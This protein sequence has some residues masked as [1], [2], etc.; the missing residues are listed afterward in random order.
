MPG[1]IIEFKGICKRFPGVTAL[2]DVSFSI[3]RG[4]IHALIGENGAGKSTLLRIL[5]G[6]YRQDSGE[7]LINGQPVSLNSPHDSLKYGIALIHQEL[8]L[9]LPLCVAENIFLGQLPK[10]R[11]L[12][13]IDW[14]RMYA[15]ASQFMS[16]IGVDIDPQVP[17]RYLSTGQRQQI[18]I[19]RALASRP[20]ILIMDE[21]TSAL[22][23]HEVEKLFS[24]IR[25]LRNEGITVIFISHILDEIREIAERLTVLRDGRFILTREL[26]EITPRELSEAMLGHTISEESQAYSAARGKRLLAVKNLTS[27][28][29]F[30]DVSFE[31]FEGEIVGLAGLLGAGKTELLR[32]LYGLD[33]FEAGEILFMEEK[34]RVGE[35]KGAIRRGMFLVPEDR[36]DEGLVLAMSISENITLPYLSKLTNLGFV[37]ERQ[38]AEVS[39]EYIGKLSVRTPS[40]NQKVFLLSGGN[41]QKVVLARWLSMKPKILLLDQP[42]RGIDVGAKE[43]IHELMKQLAE[44]GV[45]IIF[46]ATEIPELLKVCSRIFIMSNGKLIQ[47]FNAATCTE[48]EILLSIVGEVKNGH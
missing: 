12:G 36:K 33:A 7:I 45:G 19:C 32:A 34:V 29:K 16:S 22:T 48:R 25:S 27:A 24:T 46:I 13:T 2:D 42:T 8:N 4:E 44:E 37:S 47:E 41:Q 20:K 21:P 15:D 14:K 10:R 31:L 39:D 17:V 30:Q 18:E 11:L 23:E 40:R 26:S 35:T 1:I 3:K 38:K 6:V 9:V 43:E 5:A 28:G